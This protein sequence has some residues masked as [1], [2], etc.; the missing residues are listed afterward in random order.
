LAAISE[1]SPRVGIESVIDF[2]H[3]SGGAV[4]LDLIA[5]LIQS[6]AP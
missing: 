1:A 5:G 2:S 3:R 6:I 4:D